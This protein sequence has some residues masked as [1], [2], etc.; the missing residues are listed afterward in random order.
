MIRFESST[1]LAARLAIAALLA[2][3]AAR[4][5]S[6]SETVEIRFREEPVVPRGIVRLG[7]VADILGTTETIRRHWERIALRPAP[8]AG[9][10]VTIRRS[11]VRR[12]LRLESG[13]TPAVRFT[14]P[15]EVVLNDR[16]GMRE[17][18]ASAPSGVVNAGRGDRSTDRVSVVVARRPL[19]RGTL[20][21]EDD[22]RLASLSDA[23]LQHV[24]S[25]VTSLDAVLGKELKRAVRRDQPVPLESLDQPLMVR[26]RQDVQVS[27]RRGGIVVRMTGRAVED[28]R[29]GATIT[30]ENPMSKGRF[31]A[32]VIGPGKVE[33]GSVPRRSAAADTKTTARE[34]TVRR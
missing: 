4:S 15:Q 21:G 8:R 16:Y 26:R 12:V 31:S 25:W 30:I 17:A 11:D 13:G 27:V 5:A 14:G 6:A 9:R 20:I 3:L 7:H 1:C 23:D 28:G 22:V 34:G 29:L 32:R 24:S 19:S 2:T 10:R 33:V 18:V